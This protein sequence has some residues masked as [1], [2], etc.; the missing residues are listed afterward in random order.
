MK[1]ASI[2]RLMNRNFHFIKSGDEHQQQHQHKEEKNPLN[3]SQCI[4]KCYKKGR[5]EENVQEEGEKSFLNVQMPSRKLFRYIKHKFLKFLDVCLHSYDCCT[6]FIL[7]LAILNMH[8]F[9][10]S[11]LTVSSL[12][13]SFLFIYLF[14]R[15]SVIVWQQ[16]HCEMIFN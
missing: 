3:L 10:M 11:S 1:K 15:M 5:G 4:E 6:S 12:Y 14:A 9:E 8:S 2:E 16:K 13:L 7:Q